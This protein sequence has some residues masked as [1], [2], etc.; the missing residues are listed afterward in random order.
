MKE[1]TLKLPQFLFEGN[2]W[3]GVGGTALV[4]LII[5]YFL[6]RALNNCGGWR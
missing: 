3:L 4:V 5:M 6:L 2:F 1:I